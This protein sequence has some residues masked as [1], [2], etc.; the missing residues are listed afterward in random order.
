MYIFLISVK[1][2]LLKQKGILPALISKTNLETITFNGAETQWNAIK[3]RILE[4]QRKLKLSRP[5][6]CKKTADIV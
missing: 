5:K 1:Y 6:F 4:Q 3:G 2:N